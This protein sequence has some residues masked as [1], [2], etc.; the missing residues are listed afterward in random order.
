MKWACLKM[1]DLCLPRARCLRG[2]A[3]QISFTQ[4]INAPKDLKTRSGKIMSRALGAISNTD[5]GDVMT[6]ANPEIVF[7]LTSMCKR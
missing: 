1:P 4:E 6:R 7:E 3:N 5:V 2:G